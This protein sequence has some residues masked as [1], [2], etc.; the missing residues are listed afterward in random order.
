MSVLVIAP[1]PDD[2]S[3][4]CGGTLALHAARGERVVVA[5]SSPRASSGCASCRPPR[6]GACARPRRRAPPGCSGSP[7]CTSCGSPTG[8]W[9]TTWRTRRARCARCWPRSRSARLRA[10]RR[11]VAPRPP[12]RAPHPAPRDG[13]RRGRARGAAAL[14]GVDAAGRVR[15]IEDVGATM[16]RKL[17]AVRCHRSQLATFRYDRAVRGLERVPRRPRGAVRTTRGPSPSPL[18]TGRR[19]SRRTGP[20]APMTIT[21]PSTVARARRCASGPAPPASSCTRAARAPRPRR[22]VRHLPPRRG[23]RRVP[24]RDVVERDLAAMAEAGI[25]AVRTYTVPPR[26][27]L[28]AAQRHGCA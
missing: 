4:G 8:I 11:G 2:E 28:D 19:R 17:A 15:P 24:A 12:G 26:W 13:R 6:R 18:T 22:H 7:R 5:S 27:L 9:A 16:A 21:H 20:R 3:I 1:H 10:A 14:R 25:N 23:R